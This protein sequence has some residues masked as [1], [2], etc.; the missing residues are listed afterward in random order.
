MKEYDLKEVGNASVGN[1]PALVGMWSKAK[2]FLLQTID[3]DRPI[4]IELTAKQAKVLTEVRDFWLQE[5]SFPEL[6]DFFFK[7]LNI[8]GKKN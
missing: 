4:V 1:L 8:F 5:I 2:H 3:L 7:D 6:H